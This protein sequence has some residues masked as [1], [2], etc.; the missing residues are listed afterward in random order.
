MDTDVNTETDSE[1]EMQNVATMTDCKGPA[2]S[3]AV[4]SFNDQIADAEEKPQQ[5]YLRCRNRVDT[6]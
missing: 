5:E 4:A 3:A 1:V 2:T 6:K